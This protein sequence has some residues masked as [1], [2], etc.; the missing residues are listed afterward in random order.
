MDHGDHSGHGGMEH[1]M[2]GMGHAVPCKMSMVANSDPYGVCL[3]FPALQIGQTGLSL[4]F[5]LS[6]VT[7]VS[8]F[9]EYLRL[10][11]ST[12]DRALR[13]NLRGGLGPSPS[14]SQPSSSGTPR[15]RSPV[16]RRP[17]AFTDGEEALLGGGRG[18]AGPGGQGARYWGVVRLPWLVQARRSAGYAVHVALTFYIMLLVMSYNAQI[19][20]AVI[21]GAFLGHFLFQRRIDLDAPDELD[22]KGLA[23]H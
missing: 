5:W 6:F 16:G 9:C 22:G 1:D 20:G 17:S 11:L 3:V 18:G 15:P 23:C 13:S 7:L 10:S 12:F 14:Y 2:P 21:L 19:I 4:L 8:I